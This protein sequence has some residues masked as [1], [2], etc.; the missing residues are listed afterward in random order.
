MSQLGQGDY[1]W[2]T[3][4]RKKIV[5]LVPRHLLSHSTKNHQESSHGGYVVADS[6]YCWF[7]YGLKLGWQ[8]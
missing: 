8:I 7:G 1:Q 3:W 4:I 5:P 6:I 2:L